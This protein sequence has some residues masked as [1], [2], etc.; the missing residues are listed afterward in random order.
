MCVCVC[1]FVCA[2]VL[3]ISFFKLKNV[4][5]GVF[6]I[7]VISACYDIDCVVCFDN[8]IQHQKPS[9]SQ[10]KSHAILIQQSEDY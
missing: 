1:V 4:Y 9:F 3:A 10:I 6:K 7:S 5:H 8:D 2:I